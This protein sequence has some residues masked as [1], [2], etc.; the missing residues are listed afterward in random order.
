MNKILL[1]VGGILILTSIMYNIYA[2]GKINKYQ[3]QDKEDKAFIKDQLETTVMLI[4]EQSEIHKS[5]IKELKK[6][7]RNSKKLQIK[8]NEIKYEIRNI[9]YRISPNELRRDISRYRD[10]IRDR[11]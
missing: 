10:S 5:L 8:Q 3:A 11:N 9:P 7:T 2:I 4:A 1:W 6:S